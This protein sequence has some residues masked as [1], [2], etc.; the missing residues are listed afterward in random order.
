MTQQSHYWAYVLRKSELKDACTPVF[1]AALFT[2]A[3]TTQMSIDR[4]MDKEVVVHMHNGII[5]TYNKKHI[6]VS[7]NEVDEPR[8]YYIAL[9]KSERERQIW[10]INT[11]IW[12]LE[13]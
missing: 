13:R 4:W 2:I 11:Y 1:I 5:L 7:T 3:R 6:R 9:S 8:A 12:N 10:Y